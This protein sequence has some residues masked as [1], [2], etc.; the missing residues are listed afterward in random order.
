MVSKIMSAVYNYTVHLPSLFKST[1][2]KPYSE[3]LRRLMLS[4]V[5]IFGPVIGSLVD[6]KMISLHG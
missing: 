2:S 5:A 4:L 3:F 1:H 6:T